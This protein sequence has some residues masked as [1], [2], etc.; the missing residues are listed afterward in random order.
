M[1]I[2][3]DLDDF[4]IEKR[5]SQFKKHK[6]NGS[7]MLEGDETCFFKFEDGLIVSSGFKNVKDKNKVIELFKKIKKGRIVTDIDKSSKIKIDYT[8]IPFVEKYLL[9][10][11]SEKVIEGDKSLLGICSV[12]QSLM[13]KSKAFKE[14]FIFVRGKEKCFAAYYGGE[15]TFFAILSSNAHHRIILKRLMPNG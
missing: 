3:L 6:S 15:T 14:N 5:I 4:D 9:I 10:D 12:M 7:I 8:K 13:K 2:I 1:K 11:I